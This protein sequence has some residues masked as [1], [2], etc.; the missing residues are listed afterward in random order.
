MNTHQEW[1][2]NQV[3]QSCKAGQTGLGCQEQL[4]CQDARRENNRESNNERPKAMEWPPCEFHRHIGSGCRLMT[5]HGTRIV[6][7]GQKATNLWLQMSNL[8]IWPSLDEFRRE[9]NSYW[10]SAE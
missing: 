1:A 9:M 6:N 3:S 5:T 8:A 7:Q 2:P 4:I 10:Q